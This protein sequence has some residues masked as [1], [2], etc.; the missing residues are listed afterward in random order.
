MSPAE[1]FAFFWRQVLTFAVTAMGA[2]GEARS[3]RRL[4]KYPWAGWMG[5]NSAQSRVGSRTSAGAA[6]TAPGSAPGE[7]GRAPLP[8][9]RGRWHARS[10]AGF[11]GASSGA[12]AT[13]PHGS[14][15]S[16]A[17]RR[18]FL[19]KPALSILD[20]WPVSSY[21]SSN[22]VEMLGWISR[23]DTLSLLEQSGP[24]RRPRRL[25]SDS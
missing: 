15:G 4:A 6:M 10:S 11:G 2:P 5:G 24:G 23:G 22:V 13:R 14:S 3:G 7:A 19:T 18:R 16:M 17:L 21:R 20:W 9:L 1:Y 12:A 8:G 25:E